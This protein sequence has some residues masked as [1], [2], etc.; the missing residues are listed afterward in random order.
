MDA[1]AGRSASKPS[2]HSFTLA[3][4]AMFPGKT[5]ETMSSCAATAS[6]AARA[7]QHVASAAEPFLAD[8]P[9]RLQSG[10]RIALTDGS[11]PVIAE[12]CRR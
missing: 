3:L 4:A 1:G 7:R 11:K 5:E 9:R 2:A 6:G 12:T 8:D 10:K